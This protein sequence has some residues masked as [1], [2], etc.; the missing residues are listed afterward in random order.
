MRST[1][2]ELGQ[3]IDYK[4]IQSLPLNG[5][6]FQ[7]LV[8]L[9]PGAIPR[10]FADFA[11]NPAAA[12]ARSFVHHSVNGMPWSGNNY[13]L[14]GVANNEPLN[15][16][17]NVTPPLEAIQEFKVQTNNPSAEFG[18]FGGAVVNLTIRSGTQPLQRLGVRVLPR[19]FAELPEL[20]R[21]DEGAVQLPSVRRHLRRADPPEQGVLL[22]GLSGPAAGSGPHVPLH[23][24]DRRDA[25]RQPERD[26]AT[27]ST[28]RSPASGSTGNIIPAGR[29]NPI[30]RRV[31]A[32]WPLPEPSRPRQQLRREQRADQRSQRVRRARRRQL[33]ARGARSSPAF[34]APTA[35]SSSRRPATSS[36][37][38]ATRRSPATTTPSSATPTR[39]RARS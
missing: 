12:G 34:R 3:V 15:A 6:L 33:R 17:I 38:G 16:F 18:V 28:I 1:S 2:S 37:K 9:T 36:W 8:T 32:I 20:L 35:T 5:R 21:R 22:R 27:R 31:A 7:Q 24:A 30:A 13:L 23:G 25:D 11:E 14:D 4:Q 39:S 19:R 29:I 10:G 26:R